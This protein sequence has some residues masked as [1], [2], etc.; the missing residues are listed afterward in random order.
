VDPLFHRPV[1][2][3]RYDEALD[4]VLAGSQICFHVYDR[5]APSRS[6]DALLAE[7]DRDPTRIFWG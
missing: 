7:V 4:V 6:V 3:Q 1:P 2:L 5:V